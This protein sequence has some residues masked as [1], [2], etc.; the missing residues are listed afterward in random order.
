VKRDMWDF[1]NSNFYYIN[2][3]DVLESSKQLRKD[4]KTKLYLSLLCYN[5]RLIYCII[6]TIVRVFIVY[7][8]YIGHCRVPE[9]YVASRLTMSNK[10]YM[11]Q[12]SDNEDPKLLF[13][14]I[15][16]F[17]LNKDLYSSSHAKKSGKMLIFCFW[18]YLGKYIS[19]I[20]ISYAVLY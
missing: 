10:V 6:E 2:I 16:I 8:Q 7:S 11:L 13:K 14:I 3:S 18:E 12:V 4:S 15:T 9:G 20:I 5:T 1:I 19:K 17:P